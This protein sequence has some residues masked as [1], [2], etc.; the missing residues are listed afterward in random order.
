V[1]ETSHGIF[2]TQSAST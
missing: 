2:T 1:E